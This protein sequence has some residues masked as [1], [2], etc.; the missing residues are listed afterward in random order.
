MAI[1]GQGPHGIHALTELVHAWSGPDALEV[2]CYDPVLPGTGSGFALDQPEF[3][4]LNIHTRGV[5]VRPMEP[6]SEWLR[7]HGIDP[8]GE[9]P[10]HRVGAYFHAARTRTIQEPPT[11]VRVLT[12]PWPVSGITRTEQ[13]WLVESDMPRIVDEVLL[14][15]GHAPD[16]DDRLAH[17]WDPEQP[18][19]LVEAVYPVDRWLNEE[20][21]P[22]GCTVA[23]RGAALT[24]VDAALALTEGRPRSQWPARILPLGVTGRFVMATPSH[25]HELLPDE[26]EAMDLL[27]ATMPPDPM[28]VVD[29][30]A[31]AATQ[32]MVLNG[33]SPDLA[34]AEVHTTITTGWEP[35]LQEAPRALSALN[36]SI[37]HAERAARPGAAWMLGRAWATLRP[38]VVSRLSFAD[39][40]ADSWQHYRE[41]ASSLER[42]GF[43]PP[44]GTAIR[45]ADLCER[46]VIDLSWLESGV[47]VG[48]RITNL[49]AGDSQPD[50][51]VDAVLSPP[52][53]RRARTPLIDDLAARGHVRLARGRRGLDIDRDGTCLGRDGQP[54]AGLA[55][56]GLPVEDV[57][58]GNDTLDR[59]LSDLARRWAR[60]VA[61][62]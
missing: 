41:V 44:L 30:V 61:A 12:H 3:L 29:T 34:R 21:V 42:F 7:T 28:G 4:R 32:L 37:A 49:P 15:T 53:A 35:D 1:I 2:H 31:E 58:I 33:H 17:H 8:D 59:S 47:Q 60:R 38:V 10:R 6:L 62:A 25:G 43:G 50:V 46:G 40:G 39:A 14:A 20:Q 45:I 9:V 26:Q 56:V 5:Q 18:T 51:V 54:T 23:M 22:A 16:H 11:G 24:F 57:V 55:A 13:G 19:R 48:E 27:A 36:R 52:G